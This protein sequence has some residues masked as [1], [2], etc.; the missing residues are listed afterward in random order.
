L[1]KDPTGNNKGTVLAS[2]NKGI[3]KSTAQV[4]T[5]FTIAKVTDIS[6]DYYFSTN[7]ND[8]F[9][10]MLDG[11]PILGISGS[12]NAGGWST[13]YN[14]Y[15]SYNSV[16]P[17]RWSTYTL[18]GIA[19]GNHT[20]TIKY[21]KGNYGLTG[22]LD[23]VFVGKINGANLLT[24]YNAAYNGISPIQVANSSMLY[25]S[26]L[27]KTDF[28]L[29]PVIPTISLNGISSSL[30]IDYKI[31]TL[32]DLSARTGMYYDSLDYFHIITRLL[33]SIGADD[34]SFDIRW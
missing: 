7:S 32:S 20:L 28:N 15:S 17:D 9:Y 6:I 5:T 3:L 31:K 4:S 12:I 10:I 1:Q 23:E 27:Y 26:L 13:A 8:W 11:S 2:T 33:V 19:A 30:K 29:F 16:Y 25:K 24:T 22:G 34:Q 18:K 21:E 14:V